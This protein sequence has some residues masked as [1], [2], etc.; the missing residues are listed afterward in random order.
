MHQTQPPQAQAQAG[1]RTPF[2]GGGFFDDTGKQVPHLRGEP[3]SDVFVVLAGTLVCVCHALDSDTQ[4]GQRAGHGFGSEHEQGFRKPGFV[5]KVTSVPVGTFGRGSFFTA[6]P[7]SMEGMARDLK[8]IRSRTHPQESGERLLPEALPPGSWMTVHAQ[9]GA[10]CLQVPRQAVGAIMPPAVGKAVVWE[11]AAR[12]QRWLRDALDLLDTRRAMDGRMVRVAATVSP[13]RTARAAPVVSANATATAVDVDA[14]PPPP[15]REKAGQPL[16]TV[17]PPLFPLSDSEDPLSDSVAPP[18][19]P[20]SPI[21]S[22]ARPGRYPGKAATTT[23]SGRVDTKFRPATPAL[24]LPAAL[25]SAAVSPQ[26]ILKS[27]EGHRDEQERLVAARRRVARRQS[28][29]GE[30]DQA[31]GEERERLEG[32]RRRQRQKE[33]D[34]PEKRELRFHRPSRADEQV[35]NGLMGLYE[36]GGKGHLPE[37]PG[38]GGGGALAALRAEYASLAPRASTAARNTNSSSGRGRRGCG[39]SRGGATGGVGSGSGSGSVQRRLGHGTGQGP[40]AVRAVSPSRRREVQVAAAAMSAVAARRRGG[41]PS[42]GTGSPQMLGSAELLVLGGGVPDAA[43]VV[44]SY[45]DSSAGSHPGT[46]GSTRE[47]HV[48]SV[49]LVMLQHEAITLGDSVKRLGSPP[50]P[51]PPLPPSAIVDNRF[52]AD[53]TW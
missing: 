34:L 30:Q 7:G 44:A 28:H 40:A 32:Q 2:G 24:M 47:V 17:V 16:P 15:L 23:P 21:R 27:G 13:I 50:A 22:S 35:L 45:Y 20:L 33:R 53:G 4:P 9:A 11:A 25:P 52:R 51:S 26:Q 12:W 48:P 14:P 41:G 31:R 18:L 3:T 36:G 38:A 1:A 46:S 39:R 5:P 49:Q 19:P 6:Q 43:A 42:D 10:R 29:Q 8:P 37:G